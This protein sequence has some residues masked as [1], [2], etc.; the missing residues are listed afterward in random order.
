MET[1]FKTETFPAFLKNM[2]KLLAQKG[3]KH[4][5]GNEVRRSHF[6]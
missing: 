4:F 3:G 1:K 5:A 2:E 6:I